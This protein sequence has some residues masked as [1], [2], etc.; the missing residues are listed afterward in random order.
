MAGIV[1]ASG[2]NRRETMTGNLRLTMTNSM[3]SLSSGPS[4][5]AVPGEF[6]SESWVGAVPTAVEVEG[7]VGA[8]SCG[9]SDSAGSAMMD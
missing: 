1:P 6:P 7:G 4:V 3:L 2:Q 9:G 8:D 5:E